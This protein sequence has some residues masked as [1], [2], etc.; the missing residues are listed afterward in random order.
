MTSHQGCNV[1]MTR[2]IDVRFRS[3]QVETQSRLK[4]KIHCRDGRK[5]DDAIKKLQTSLQNKHF[6]LS[7][8][9]RIVAEIDSLT[10]S[11]KIVV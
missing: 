10:R 11:K 9:K 1:V 5:V 6:R 7:E 2:R 3:F 8:E 4:P